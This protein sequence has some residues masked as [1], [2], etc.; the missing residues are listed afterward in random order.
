MI[1]EFKEWSEKFKWKGIKFKYDDLHSVHLV[2]SKYGGI[3][4]TLQH[5]L[6]RPAKG[7]RRDYIDVPIPILKASIKYFKE[8][9]RNEEKTKKK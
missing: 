6:S 9:D 1:E 2:W 7:Y 4:I 8:C 5:N 3:Y